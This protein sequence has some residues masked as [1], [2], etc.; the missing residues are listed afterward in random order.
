MPRSG[1]GG[2]GGGGG[3]N[4]VPSDSRA[5]T[6]RTKTRDEL[7]RSTRD[8]VSASRLARRRRAAREAERKKNG[9]GSEAEGRENACRMIIEGDE[10]R[11]QV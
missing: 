5:R 7:A 9:E 1:S 11:E 10:A 3:S 8:P 6:V 4:S 2:G